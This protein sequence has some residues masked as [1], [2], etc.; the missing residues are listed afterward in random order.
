MWEETLGNAFKAVQETCLKHVNIA[1]ENSAVGLS[2]MLDVSF[3]IWKVEFSKEWQHSLPCFI[4]HLLH[5][6]IN[7]TLG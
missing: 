3:F 4:S 5:E 1:N 2:F 7:L 6:T